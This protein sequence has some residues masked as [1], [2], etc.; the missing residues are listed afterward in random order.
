MS[1]PEKTGWGNNIPGLCF[2]PWPFLSFY[3][4]IIPQKVTKNHLVYVFHPIYVVFRL[5]RPL[6]F[7]P[8][9]SRICRV[10]VLEQGSKHVYYKNGAESH[11]RNT[12]KTHGTLKQ[13]KKCVVKHETNCKSQITHRLQQFQILS[14]PAK[15]F[16]FNVW[17][18]FQTRL[19]KLNEGL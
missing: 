14:S 11:T 13:A 5:N 4:L 7:H 8:S 2:N 12:R 19:D 9:H 3:P 1:L 10:R 6:S 17:V 16:T 15:S 18:T